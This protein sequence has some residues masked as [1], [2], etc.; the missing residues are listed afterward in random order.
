VALADKLETLPGSSASA[1]S[2][3]AT[4][5][6]FGLRRHAIGVIRILVEKALPIPLP[7]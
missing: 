4:R 5:T 6:P 7:D 2:R 3:P 1:R